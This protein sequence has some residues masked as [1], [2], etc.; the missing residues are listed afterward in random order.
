MLLATARLAAG[1]AW[2][3]GCTPPGAHTHGQP[4]STPEE[5]VCA[6]VAAM[7]GVYAGDCAATVSPRDIGK[8]CSKFIAQRGALRAYLI[9]RTFS[10]FSTW[11]F[12]ERQ[13]AG[14]VALTTVPLDFAS[15]VLV[16]P[17]PERTVVLPGQ[18]P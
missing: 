5:A 18:F 10:E 2:A 12:V 6:V 4:V 17:W 11:V 7:D 3:A 8:V 9:G 1:R 14:W 16:V 13:P 15:P